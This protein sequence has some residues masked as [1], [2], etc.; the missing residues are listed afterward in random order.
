VLLL[1]AP[2][3]RHEDVVL[4][5]DRRLVGVEVDRAVIEDAAQAAATNFVVVH[6]Y[7]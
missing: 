5:E 3:K 1:Q 6:H 7:R 4:S 2:A